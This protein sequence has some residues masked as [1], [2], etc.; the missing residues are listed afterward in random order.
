MPPEADC[1]YLLAPRHA[2]DVSKPH[3]QRGTW[4][5]PDRPSRRPAKHSGALLTTLREFITQLGQMG[6]A[7]LLAALLPIVLTLFVAPPPRKPRIRAAVYLLFLSL[8][9]F[10]S[11][12]LFESDAAGHRYFKLAAHFFLLAC[13]GR[14]LFVLLT[15]G[16]FRQQAER[17]PK[18]FLDILQGM[19]YFGALLYVLGEWGVNPLS[20]A[21]GSAV[22]TVLVGLSMRDTLGN[23]FAGLALQAQQPFAVGDW[24]QWDDQ[25]AHIGRVVEINWRGTRVVTLDAVEIT[26]PHSTLGQ[27]LIVN[28]TRPERWSRRSIYFHAPLDVP[29]RTVQLLVLDTIAGSFGVQ[30]E[31][32]PSVVTLAFDERGVQYWLRFFTAEFDKRDRVDGEVRDRI[33]YAFH[34]AGIAVPPPQREIAIEDTSL[35]GKERERQKQV[36]TRTAALRCVDFLASLES[37]ALEQLAGLSWMALYAPGEI[38]LRQGEVGDVLFIIRHGEVAVLLEKPGQEPAEVER[39]GPGE[40]F[41]EMSLLTGEPRS[42]TV[43]A[44]RHCELLVVGKSAFGRLLEESP[45]LAEHVAR[46]VAQRT[47]TR[48]RKQAEQA[49]EA[50]PPQEESITRLLKRIKDFFSI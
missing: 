20:L 48:Q 38:V 43:Q 33:W 25:P 37:A 9:L 42:A 32:A 13:L 50:K 6:G 21:T 22:L 4:F 11:S 45:A 26:V 49:T 24:I 8:A 5:L 14:G 29:T 27:S 40:F 2:P 30:T 39:M 12:W 47:T 18:I 10:G 28:F 1:G 35:H 19:A 16:V 34:R 31:P 41:G 46:I 44:T 23:L 15:Q 7:G 17:L 36:D 3:R